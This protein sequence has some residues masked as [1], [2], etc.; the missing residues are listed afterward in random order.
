MAYD[1]GIVVPVFRSGELVKQLILELEA[2]FLPDIKLRICLVDDS[3]DTATAN[4][5]KENCL[6]PAVTI[7]QL[8]GNYG[9][10]AATLCG[11][12][13]L[14]TCKAYGTIDDD[15]EQPV[16]VFYELYQRVQSGCDLAYG[17]P[18]WAAGTRP[19]LRRCGS[20][21]RD[22]V[23]SGLLG[24][25]RGIRVSSLRIMSAETAKM[26]MDSPNREHD[27]GFF[28]LS[29]AILKGA[30]KKRKKLKIENLYYRP[31]AV[32]KGKS[33]YR[34]GKLIS[35]YGKIWWYYGL[36]LSRRTQKRQVYRMKEMLRP[37]KLLILGGSNCQLHA[38]E[39]AKA[40]GLDT[41]LADYTEHPPAAAI[42]AVHEKIS[43][44]DVKACIEAAGYYG[45][46][47]VMTMGTDQ[48]VYTAACVSQALGLPGHLSVDQAFSVTNKKKMKQIL[49]VAGIPVAKDMIVDRNTSVSELTWMRGPLVIKPLDSQ[50]QRGIY[51]EHT[52]QEILRHLA[53]T[54]SFS[55]CSE[56]LVEEFYDS[57]EVTVSGW[58]SGGK[59]YVLTITDRLLY[60]DNTHIGVC[61][62][63]RFPSV[64]SERYG[65]MAGISQRVAAA[66][67]L[68]EGPFYL[69]L[70]IGRQG[71]WVNELAARIGGAFEDVVIPWITGFNILGAVLDSAL[72]RP[73][74]IWRS[75][76]HCW[77]NP[78]SADQCAAVQLLFCRP[79]L[80][81]SITP[82]AEICSLPYIL[83]A[84]YNY[85]AGEVLPVMENATARFGHAVIGG[86]RDTIE[87]LV[88]DFYRQFSVQ[89]VDGEE[90]VQRFYP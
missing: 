39:R 81:G 4:Y 45:V 64:H 62:G 87:E 80:I 25:P 84:G 56:A 1:L 33:R 36:G 23:F 8:A 40:M 34:I 67:A 41:V 9:Q 12:Q 28:Y 90:M 37:E 88:D 69:Q 3:N 74:S 15:L 66:F 65:E 27:G 48:P 82:L 24:A 71:I 78:N 7:I 2:I 55:R 32:R 63:H 54:L 89:S 61:I 11:L 59:L 43:T 68:K 13:H 29:A 19:L 57:D 52:S 72:G 14:E 83:D 10:Q 79:G 86:T 70:L 26:V 17:I 6:R 5:L 53:D 51:K 47:G 85:Q 20:R 42:C 58:I 46:S 35:L 22:M 31:D 60:P 44:F 50:G 16:A 38:A 49:K 21:L 75:D 76:T 30:K 73:V 18:V 77:D